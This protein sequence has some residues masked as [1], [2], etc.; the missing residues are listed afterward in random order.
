MSNKYFAV[1]SLLLVSLG[2]SGCANLHVRPAYQ[3]E[4][5]EHI[6]QI[7]QIQNWKVNAKLGF[8]STDQ[9]GSVSMNWLQ[10]KANYTISLRGPLGSGFA[11]IKGDQLMAEMQFQN[12]TFYGTPEQLS[13]QSLGISL[14]FQSTLF[15]MRGIPS[16]SHSSAERISFNSSGTANSFIQSGWLIELSRYEMT[17]RGYLPRKIIGQCDDNSFKLIISEWDFAI[18]EK[19]FLAD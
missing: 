3:L 12:K 7:E 13:D 5:E 9:S 6:E 10:Q 19:A 18:N 14:P 8:K 16:P 4:W 11:L 1:I 17:D 15:W 2:L